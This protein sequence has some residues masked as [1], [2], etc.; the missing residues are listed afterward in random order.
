MGTLITVGVWVLAAIVAL[1]LCWFGL[2]LLLKIM[3]TTVVGAVVFGSWA[4]VWGVAGCA[5]A[6]WLPFTL[7]EWDSIPAFAHVLGWLGGMGAGMLAVILS[8]NYY[9]DTNIVIFTILF[10]LCLLPAIVVAWSLY[11]GF[12]LT[13]MILFVAAVVKLISR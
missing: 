10:T 12:M 4:F 6:G 11:L 5:H 7:V 1:M 13:V 3:F 8:Y 2:K 9:D